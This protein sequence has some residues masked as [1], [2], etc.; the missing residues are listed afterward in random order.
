MGVQAAGK[1]GEGEE[2]GMDLFK[3]LVVVVF[4]AIVLGFLTQ[5]LGLIAIDSRAFEKL[6]K[7]LKTAEALPGKMLQEE[8]LFSAGEGLS[9]KAFETGNRIMGFE[10]NSSWLCCP[11]AQ[12]CEKSIIEWNAGKV[13]VKAQQKIL[14]S[15][16]CEKAAELFSCKSYFGETPAQLEILS[17]TAKQQF[18]V[19]REKP[20]I[21]V[22]FRNVG[23][24]PAFAPT[25]SLELLVRFVE[26]GLEK[27]RK[28]EEKSISIATEKI[29]VG[30]TQKAIIELDLAGEGRFEAI[31]TV[32][33]KNSGSDS[34]SV[35]F[36][37]FKSKGSCKADKERAK[38]LFWIESTPAGDQCGEK[39]YCKECEFGYECLEAWEQEGISG[40]EIGNSGFAYKKVAC[41]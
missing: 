15:T 30:E 40:L 28:L 25:M 26:E 12:V 11:E 14:V 20:G 9:S 19:R 3:T 32:Q 16:R 37:T 41:D 36:S 18:D 22:T 4:A 21:E 24:Q 39:H 38:E 7:Q 6:Q 5:L 27:K 31:I 23:K 33:E 34:K 17:I 29:S 35:Q 2:I 1:G 10:C 13:I 8:L